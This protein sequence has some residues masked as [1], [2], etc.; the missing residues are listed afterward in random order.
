MPRTGCRA[1]PGQG[2]V[3][4]SLAFLLIALGIFGG[5]DVSRSVF[6]THNL[7]RSAQVIARD[8]AL[9]SN[10]TPQTP[11][12]QVDI[13]SAIAHGQQQGNR[14]FDPTPPTFPSPCPASSGTCTQRVQNASGSI[15][16]VGTPDLCTPL[17]I[18]VTIQGSFTP[19]S[20]LFIGG[21]TMT[22]GESATALTAQALQ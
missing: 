18:T 19:A 21:R 20:S 11:L 5:L 15:A 12:C 1:L 14:S 4:F 13:A 16:I 2:T 10:T 6:L 3:E 22:L 17:R 7:T 9:G 8:L